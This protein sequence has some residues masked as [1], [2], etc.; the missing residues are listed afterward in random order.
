M[1]GRTRGS[2]AKSTEN[3]DGDRS[4]ACLGDRGARLES[5]VEAS[6]LAV[7]SRALSCEN[8]VRVPTNAIHSRALVLNTAAK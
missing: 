7:F 8:K 3:A 5:Y 1:K 6:T 4:L 2:I